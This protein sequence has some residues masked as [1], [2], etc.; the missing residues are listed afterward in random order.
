MLQ[1]TVEQGQPTGQTWPLSPGLTS[2]G[3]SANNDIILSG[4]QV[5]RV[6]FVVEMLGPDQYALTDKSTNGTL[7]N[8]RRAQDHTPLKAGDLIQVGDMVLRCEAGAAGAEAWPSVSPAPEAA[9]W[10]APVSEP[11]AWPMAAPAPAP[12][13]ASP[14]RPASNV[15]PIAIGVIAAIL[16]LTAVIAAPIF[17]SGRKSSMPTSAAP[18]ATTEAS[19]PITAT[20]EIT[21]TATLTAVAVVTPTPAP[22]PSPS[23][24]PPLVTATGRVKSGQGLNVRAAPDTAGQRLY[25]LG[26]QTAIM[27]TGRNGAGDWYL[28]QCQPGQPADQKCWVFADLVDWDPSAS[29]L[30]VVQP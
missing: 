5:S 27:A 1:L 8:G 16:I 25:T 12:M 20:V 21:P 6:H 13:P 15:I 23:P 28:I 26:Q 14:R 18:T 9:A 10:S 11:A 30:P 17:L 7:V 24:T 19:V 2:V 3:R 22:T 4:N 29:Q